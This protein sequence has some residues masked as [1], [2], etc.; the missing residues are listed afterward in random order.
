M[1]INAKWWNKQND[2]S[3]ERVKEAFKRDW[4]QTK[5]DMGGRHPDTHQN[6]SDTVKQAAGLESIPPRGMPTEEEIDDPYHFVEVA[7]RFGYGARSQYG[8]QYSGWDKTLETQLET[9]W[10]EAY[11]GLDW[12]KYKDAVQRGWNYDDTQR[13]NKAA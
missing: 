1:E 9:D 3:W 4:D 11:V 7:Y 13:L 5:H 12:E 2:S 10:R 6:V 8:K